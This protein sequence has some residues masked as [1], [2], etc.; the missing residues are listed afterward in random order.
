M[1]YGLHMNDVHG[2]ETKMFALMRN[3]VKRINTPSAAE[4]EG[5]ALLARIDGEIA[6]MTAAVEGAGQS[7]LA[8][9]ARARLAALKEAAIAARALRP[10]HIRFSGAM[11]CLQQGAVL[12]PMMGQAAGQ[13]LARVA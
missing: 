9:V 7:S 5:L 6:V 13:I 11:A 12:A 2:M 8:A 1:C 10:E 4:V 3:V